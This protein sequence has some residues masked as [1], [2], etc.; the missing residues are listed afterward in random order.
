MAPL[1]PH[2]SQPSH[3]SIQ[4]VIIPSDPSDFTTKSISKVTLPPYALFAKLSFP[5]C[6]KASK[7]TYA[8]VQVGRGEHVDLNSDLVYINHSCEPSVVST[9]SIPLLS[10][11]VSRL[12]HSHSLPLIA[13][14]KHKLIP[15]QM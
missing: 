13:P 7:P 9:P 1:T 3:P 11:P 4:Q 10:S 12:S 6:T 14:N 5:P 15:T 2:W 8:T